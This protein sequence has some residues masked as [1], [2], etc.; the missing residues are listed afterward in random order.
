MFIFVDRKFEKKKI[1]VRNVRVLVTSFNHHFSDKHLSFLT[2]G[3]TSQRIYFYNVIAATFYFI[4]ATSWMLS[5][6]IFPPTV[7]SSFSFPVPTLLSDFEHNP[8]IN[9]PTART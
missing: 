7:P 4:Y 1:M 8:M 5:A 6:S 2:R 3:I 9:L